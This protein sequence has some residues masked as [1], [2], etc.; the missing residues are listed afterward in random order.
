M[1][2]LQYNLYTDSEET[3]DTS[4][5]VECAKK[6]KKKRFSILKYSANN[7]KKKHKH[8]KSE[9]DYSGL[10]TVSSH[11]VRY[12]LPGI[13]KNNNYNNYTYKERECSSEDE[14]EVDYPKVH[15]SKDKCLVGRVPLV[16]GSRS[17]RGGGVAILVRKNVMQPQQSTSSTKRKRKTKLNR[18]R[19][20]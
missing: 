14:D 12:K 10:R 13:L 4:S 16:P 15:L 9:P 19:S 6:K 3:E 11:R 2:K 20:Y 1:G 5:S 7:V 17:G 8:S 18:K